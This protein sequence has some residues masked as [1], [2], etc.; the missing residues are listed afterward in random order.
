MRK[1]YLQRLRNC[2]D[3]AC[4]PS[5]GWPLPSGSLMKLDINV[6]EAGSNVR[7]D[8]RSVGSGHRNVGSGQRNV[9]SGHRNVGSSHRNVDAEHHDVV[10]GSSQR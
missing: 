3:I 8:Y 2:Y 10:E 5:P 6:I 4:R 7:E 1:K 9:G